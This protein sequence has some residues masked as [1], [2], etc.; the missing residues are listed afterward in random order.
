MHCG[1]PMTA[2]TS[3][4]RI[5]AAVLLGIITGGI[6]F[7]L[8]ALI[9]GIIN[10]ITRLNMTVTTNIAENMFSALLLLFLIV[11]C[12]VVFYHKVKTTPVSEPEQEE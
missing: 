6:L 4:L 7:F 5:A 12:V 3:P 2:R 10:D 9:L 1:I 8:V 11:A